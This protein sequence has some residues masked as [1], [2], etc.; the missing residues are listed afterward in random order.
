MALVRI[1]DRISRPCYTFRPFER[2]LKTSL[3]VLLSKRT[4]QVGEKA[5]LSRVFREKDVETFAKLT[6]DV[7]PVHLDEKFAQNTRFGRRIVH[8]VLLNG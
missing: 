2:S 3:T 8:G 5:E 6:G 4:F 7:N 1:L